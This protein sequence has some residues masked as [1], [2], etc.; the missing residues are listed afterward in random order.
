MEYVYHT[1][2]P[3]ARSVTNRLYFIVLLD[4]P[5]SLFRGAYHLRGDICPCKSFGGY[6]H[7]EPKLSAFPYNRSNSSFN[8]GFGAVSPS[9]TRFAQSKYSRWR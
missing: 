7:S 8:L 1:R 9:T 6:L 4:L 5:S 2:V 3:N